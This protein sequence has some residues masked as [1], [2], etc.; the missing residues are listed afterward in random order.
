[1]CNGGG[2]PQKCKVV[3]ADGN[4]DGQVD[5]GNANTNGL[6]PYITLGMTLADALDPWGMRY[7]IILNSAATDMQRRH[8]EHAP[9]RRWD[10]RDDHLFKARIAMTV[11]RRHALSVTVAEI[12]TY[13][14][15][16]AP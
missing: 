15:G 11:G 1:M 12:R 6:V 4:S 7:R 14:V 9:H 16:L 2:A 5:T 8:L 3:L 10:R 13:L